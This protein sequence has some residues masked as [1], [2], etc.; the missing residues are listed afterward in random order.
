MYIVARQVA[1][2]FRGVFVEQSTELV[3]DAFCTER[4]GRVGLDH[5]LVLDAVAD[6]QKQTSWTRHATNCFN[7]HG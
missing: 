6:V 1:D 4:D 7:A 2:L 5:V 3:G